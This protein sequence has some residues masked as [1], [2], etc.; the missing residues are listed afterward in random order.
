[1][2]CFLFQ[3]LS[4]L[5]KYSEI[6]F[7]KVDVDV[8]KVSTLHTLFNPFPHTAHLQQTTLK[9]SMQEYGKSMKNNV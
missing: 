2:L 4:G 3:T 8:N 6:K 7:V 5:A 1:M 9:S